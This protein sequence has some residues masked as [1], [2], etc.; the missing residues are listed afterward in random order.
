MTA[1]C[2]IYKTLSAIPLSTKSLIRRH[3]LFIHKNNLDIG[4]SA[5]VVKAK[6]APFVY[7]TQ[8]IG[9]SVKAITETMMQSLKS[10]IISLFL[11]EHG[12]F[13]VSPMLFLVYVLHDFFFKMKLN[14]QL[15]QKPRSARG[16]QRTVKC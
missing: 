8:T 14:N 10:R 7:E 11:C 13:Y 3:R 15:F 4:K 9:N 5:S 2:W 12:A 16:S 6:S 1:L